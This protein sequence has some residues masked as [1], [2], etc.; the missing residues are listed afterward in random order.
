MEDPAGAP[1][2]GIIAGSATAPAPAGALLHELDGNSD[3]EVAAQISAAAERL[4]TEFIQG[5]TG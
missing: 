1:T 4:V 2:L 3:T 5:A